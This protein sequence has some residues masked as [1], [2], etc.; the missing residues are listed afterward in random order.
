MTDLLHTLTNVPVDKGTLG[1]HEI[2]F[3][4]KTSP[5]RRNGRGAI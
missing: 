4:I 3:V 5:R 1:V 2:E